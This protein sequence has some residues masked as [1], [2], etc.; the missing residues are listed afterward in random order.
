MKLIIDFYKDLDTIN[1]ILFWGIIIVIILLLIFSL[2][3]I[4][5]NK[6]LKRMIIEN[7]KKTN[8]TVSDIP[9]QVNVQN[10]YHEEIKEVNN[11]EKTNDVIKEKEEVITQVEMPDIPKV[12]NHIEETKF[13]AEEHVIDYNQKEAP[14]IEE[15]KPSNIE[16]EIK[17]EE[18]PTGPYQR[19]VLRQMPSQTSPI[20]IVRVKSE[21]H[22]EKEEAKELNDILNIEE[23]NTEKK[24]QNDYVKITENKVYKQIDNTNKAKSN[25]LEE[26]KNSLSKATGNDGIER[27]DYEMQQEEDAIISYEELMQ[28]KDTIKMIDEEE[29]VISI[30]EL[31]RKKKQNERLYQITEEE[32]ND[33]FIKELKDFRND[34]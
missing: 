21:Q 33:E 6:K 12:E 11:I 26:L 15:E 3:L 32:E 24:E 23:V 25:Y 20:G 1:L 31:L 8:E 2:I 34:L 9:I 27:T 18:V 13:I 7:S 28:K 19:N 17:K 10:N 29:S 4:N 5:K 30:E 14:K 22:K 16:I